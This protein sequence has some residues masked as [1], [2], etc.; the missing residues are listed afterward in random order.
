MKLLSKKYTKLQIDTVE[1]EL[2]I[3]Q[4]LTILNS[5]KL[6]WRNLKN[7]FN[8]SS[9]IFSLHS[10]RI[11]RALINELKKMVTIVSEKNPIVYKG[12]SL[13]LIQMKCI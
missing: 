12:S 2:R 5:S 3:T 8:V 7:N 10:T 11:K 4:A 9:E 1:N 6:F 13:K